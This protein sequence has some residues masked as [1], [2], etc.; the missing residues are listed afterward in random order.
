M[1]SHIVSCP[2]KKI[3]GLFPHIFRPIKQLQTAVSTVGRRH[4]FM[5]SDLRRNLQIQIDQLRSVISPHL[6]A[7]N[8]EAAAATTQ[9]EE[10]HQVTTAQ[11]GNKCLES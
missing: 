1:E 7:Q 4:W 10:R 11:P 9:N 6:V 8:D 5:L 3:E 2:Y